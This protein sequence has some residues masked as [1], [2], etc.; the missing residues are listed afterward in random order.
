MAEVET[1]TVPDVSEQLDLLIVKYFQTLSDIF[2]CKQLLE[3]D[4]KDGFFYMAKVTIEPFCA[5]F[6][7][8]SMHSFL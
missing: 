2:K 6:L 3:N 7:Y 1:S 8:H 4:M 5:L